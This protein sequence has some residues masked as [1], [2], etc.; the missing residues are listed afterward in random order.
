M[1]CPEL[2]A[3]SGLLLKQGQPVQCIHRERST[4]H[5][6]IDDFSSRKNGE[7]PLSDHKLLQSE[8]KLTFTYFCLT[9][10]RRIVNS[11]AKRPPRTR[12]S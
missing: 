10:I 4:L 11:N 3:G 1:Q 6:Q 12:R 7:W 9:N 2:A 8:E 5:R